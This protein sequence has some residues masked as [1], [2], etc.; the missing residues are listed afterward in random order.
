MTIDDDIW[1]PPPAD[2]PEGSWRA[3]RALTA[4]VWDGIDALWMLANGFSPAMPSV[5]DELRS[6]SGRTRRP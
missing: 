5:A 1:R 4:A 2:R 3:P 6:R